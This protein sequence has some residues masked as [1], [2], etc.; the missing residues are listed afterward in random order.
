MNELMNTAETTKSGAAL[1][2]IRQPGGSA[3][4]GANR[5]FGEICRKYL[6]ILAT[7]TCY[8]E[9]VSNAV[10]VTN[11]LVAKIPTFGLESSQECRWG[12]AGKFLSLLG[13]RECCFI[14]AHDQSAENQCS[15]SASSVQEQCN[16]VVTAPEYKA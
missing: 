13:V 16:V 2:Q 4:G 8:K 1:L 5:D 15:G 12:L 7:R 6:C 9:L 3:K 14:C 10:K 11:E